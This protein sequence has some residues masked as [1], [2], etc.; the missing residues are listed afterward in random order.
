MTETKEIK[1][2]VVWSRDNC[3]YCV[4]AKNLLS[5]K[6]LE[7]EERNISE[8][9]WSREQLLEACPGARTVPQI[10]MDDTVIG[11]YDRLEEYFKNES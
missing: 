6:G 2:I 9:V 4:R 3:P 10:V 11:G 7:Y 5:V 8:G 1:K